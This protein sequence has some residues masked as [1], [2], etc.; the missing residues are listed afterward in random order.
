MA[1]LTDSPLAGGLPQF[2]LHIIDSVQAQQR[3]TGFAGDA[4]T[5]PLGE[6]G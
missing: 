6:T 2:D 4:F 3:L 1:G 5:L